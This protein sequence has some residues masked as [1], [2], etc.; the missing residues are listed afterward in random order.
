MRFRPATDNAAT[1]P[2]P[3]SRRRCRQHAP[4]TGQ[5]QRCI[6]KQP[7]GRQLQE[8]E[9]YSGILITDL[10][11]FA[12]GDPQKI[13]LGDGIELSVPAGTPVTKKEEGPG[14]WYL[15]W[16]VPAGVPAVVSSHEKSR[17]LV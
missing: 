3:R 9:R 13:D 4:G 6:G 10:R 17:R 8:V 2:S 7:V 11:Q 12:F 5:H 15:S 1:L 16:Y 14:G